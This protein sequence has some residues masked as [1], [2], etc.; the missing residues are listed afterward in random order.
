M[1]LSLLLLRINHQSNRII[2][3]T[4]EVTRLQT[5][6]EE[7]EKRVKDRDVTI[8]TNEVRIKEL[9]DSLELSKRVSQI[10]KTDLSVLEGKYGDLLAE[11]RNIPPDSSYSFLTNVA[12]PY[13]G[14]MIYPFN[15]N[16]INGIHLTYLQKLMLH[17][18]NLNLTGQVGECNKQVGLQEGVI[19]EMEGT[20]Y[21]MNSTRQDQ[22]N[23]I[24]NLNKEINIYTKQVKRN[25]RK[26]LFW[27]ITT[28]IAAGTALIFAI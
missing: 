12:Y 14:N 18:I 8:Y 6:N 19:N 21:L 3:T 10:L 26:V 16:Q 17:D 24:T 4:K 9:R 15:A 7:L 1:V 13:E 20:I 22:E 28:G 5:Q 27:K 2:R 11:T 25:K 23:I